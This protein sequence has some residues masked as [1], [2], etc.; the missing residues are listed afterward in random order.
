MSQPKRP[1]LQVAA[2]VLSAIQ[3]RPAPM[4]PAARAPHVARSLQCKPAATA[5]PA[6]ARPAG[7]PAIIQ[8]RGYDDLQI[9]Q[10]AAA[11]P[12]GVAETMPAYL[13]RITA[14]FKN[15]MNYGD[16]D[17]LRYLRK[18]IGNHRS[19]LVSTYVQ[20]NNLDAHFDAHILGNQAGVGW[21]SEAVRT[22]GMNLP[23]NHNPPVVGWSYVNWGWIAQTK[24]TYWADNI[25]VNGTVKA[26][27][28]GV[29]SFYP[30]G[31]GIAQIRR[32]ALYVANTNA[33][34]GQI[35]RGRGKETGIVIDCL[36]NGNTITSAY[37]FRP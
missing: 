17:D 1:A 33:A 5:P 30:A 6:A 10:F 22:D 8:R 21:H 24:G 4:Q 31:M 11:N 23:G 32:E 35:I 14:A 18:R 15:E 34:V 16:R 29:S 2:H 36:M 12:Q 19:L 20:T 13:T 27:N 26:G 25:V 28:N 3:M 7:A 9:N 37:P